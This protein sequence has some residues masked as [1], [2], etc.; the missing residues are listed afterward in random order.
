MG[1][2]PAAA[3]KDDSDVEPMFYDRSGT[4][5][6]L[7]TF[8]EH[9]ADDTYRFLRRDTVTRPGGE[10]L[11]VVTAWLGVDQSMGEA[12]RPLIFGT[13]A[14]DLERDSTLWENRE[15]WTATEADATAQ[16]AELVE[17]LSAP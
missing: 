2:N 10:R 7:D 9:F 6:G 16:H 3:G 11:E 1:S 5:I 15:L 13:V 14:L 8:T 4:P 12:D 17:R